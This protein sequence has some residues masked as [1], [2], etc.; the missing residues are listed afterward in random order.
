MENF[1]NKKVFLLSTNESF[2][3]NKLKYYLVSKKGLSNFK[4]IFFKLNK[5][6][7]TNY[8]ISAY[9]F[10]VNNKLL[11]EEKEEKNKANIN[12]KFQ[13]YK[14]ERSGI[15]YFNKNKNNFML[16]FKIN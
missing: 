2:L 13:N 11:K 7:S 5:I 12:V 14:S 4:K 15:I 9:Y 1:P 10:D 6:Q 16:Y 8:T 3:D